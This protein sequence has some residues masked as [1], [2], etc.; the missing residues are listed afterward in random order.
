[1]TICFIFLYLGLICFEIFSLWIYQ[2]LNAN[3]FALKEKFC[4]RRC[5]HSCLLFAILRILQNWSPQSSSVHGILQAGILEW[6]A[7]PCSRGSSQ[8]RNQSRVS[9]LVGGVFTS[10]VTR[11]ARANSI[12]LYRQCEHQNKTN[13]E[14]SLYPDTITWCKAQ[15]SPYASAC[16]K[17]DPHWERYCTAWGHLFCSGADTWFQFCLN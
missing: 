6:V 10:W 7:V 14:E 11:E 17:F 16:Y 12:L 2:I 5:A 9:C 4:V 13:P 8:P 15:V 3:L 1:M